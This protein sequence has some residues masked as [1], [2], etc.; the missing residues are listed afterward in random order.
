MHRL[1]LHGQIAE[2]ATRPRLALAG[3]GFRPFFALAAAYA[4]LIIPVWLLIVRGVLGAPAYL[5]A[6]SWHAHEMIFGFTVAVIAGFLLTAVGN[7][8]QR[9]T[10]IGTP[11]LGLAGLWL[12][13]RIAMLLAPVL[14]R[15][16]AATTDLAFLPALGWAIA[17]PLIATGNRRNFVM[18]GVIAALFAANCVVHLGALG[19]LPAHAAR[20]ACLS[21]LDVIVLLML[22]I[23]GRVLPTFTRNATG[24]ETKSHVFLDRA[25][26]LGAGLMTAIAA[27]WPES[28][29]AGAAAG[30]VALLACARAIHWATRH[31]LRVPLLWILHVGYLWLP[32]GLL[33]RALPALG[34]PLWG[35]LAT[36]A[37]TAGAIGALT[38]GM[39]ARVAL[40]HSGRTLAASP[41][42]A[43][44]FLAI[45]LS[46]VV[47]VFVPL[48][49]L[50]WHA[51]AL[52]V[53]GALW[54]LAFS[55]YLV[56]YMPILTSPRIDGKAG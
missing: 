8:T 20:L 15:G 55:L 48:L 24:V 49:A 10:L 19:A 46:A 36:H 16:L 43:W 14:P 11:L 13:G 30:V 29:A 39:M 21:A 26:A 18:I 51:S 25:T 33:L 34:V 4:A 22:V 44:A 23:S 28:R 38:L 31:T 47:R 53:A 12:L 7:W 37:L 54:T 35:S 42:M 40:G 52:I 17:R 56:V 50:R 27:A 9:E 3:K 5:D 32:I 2:P 41:A 1:Q 45:T 6:N